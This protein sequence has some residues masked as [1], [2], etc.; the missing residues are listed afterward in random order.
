MNAELAADTPSFGAH[1]QVV[2]QLAIGGMAEIYLARHAASGA[3]ASFDKEVVIKRLKPALARDARMAEMFV[4]EARIGALLSHPNT[5]QVFDAGESGGVPFI[6]MEYIRGE[7]LT[8]LCRRGLALGH[9]LPLEHAVELVR[10]AALGLGHFHNLADAGGEALGGVHCDISPTNLLVTEDGFLKVIDFGIARFAGQRYR[11]E[12]VVPGKLSYMSPEQVRREAVDRRSDVFSLGVVLYEITLGKRLFR[13]P[14]AEVKERLARAEVVPPTFVRRDY[15]GALES[16]VM[17]AL[18]ADPAERHQEAYELADELEAYLREEGMKT[19]PLAVA[20]YL[21]RL[22]VAAGGGGRD[23]LWPE[24]GDA[25]ALDFDRD[26]F[27]GYRAIAEADPQAAADWDEIEED[28]AAVA[29]A[30]GIGVELV[31]T[32]T[33]ASGDG[34]MPAPREGRGRAAPV[35]SERAAPPPERRDPA[36]APVAPP[37]A[38]ASET[39]PEPERAGSALAMLLFGLV[40]GVAG[41]AVVYLLLLG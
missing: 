4:D 7:E 35:E 21:D 24:E 11:D 32:A 12:Q 39:A 9:F 23:E 30:L 22:A 25:D 26:L 8:L 41:S 14:A 2:R 34:L 40:L 15:P 20:R 10:Q 19:G 28:D 3:D 36:P 1:Y 17:R 13:G 38:A 27:S 37:R 31:R 5:V 18:D 6:V 29:E 33:R 16:I